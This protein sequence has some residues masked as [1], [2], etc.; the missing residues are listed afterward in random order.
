MVKA[1]HLSHSPRR[2]GPAFWAVSENRQNP[3]PR[4]HLREADLIPNTAA[5]GDSEFPMVGGVQARVGFVEGIQPCHCLGPGTV[6]AQDPLG[7]GR[8]GM[9]LAW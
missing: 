1:T 7:R 9:C 3:Q 2:R 8:H 6:L 5:S 4:A